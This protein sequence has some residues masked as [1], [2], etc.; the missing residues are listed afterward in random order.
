MPLSPA[1]GRKVLQKYVAIY[2]AHLIN[3]GQ[4]IQALELYT[5]YGAPASQQNFNI[6]KRILTDIVSMSGLNTTKAYKV[7]SSLRNMMYSL[8]LELSQNSDSNDSTRKEYHT[9]LLIS[10]YYA[11][12]AAVQTDLSLNTMAA[13]LSVSLL[14]HTDIVPADK[15]FYEAGLLCKSVGWEAMAFVFTNHLLDIAEAIED[16]TLDSLDHSDFQATDIPFEIP[17]PEHLF[18]SPGELEQQKEW[19]LEVSMNQNV[20]QVLPK[21][22]RGVYEASLVNYQNGQASVPCLI[23][24]YPVLK[25]QM[26]FNQPGIGANKED[27]NKLFMASKV[28]HSPEIQDVLQFVCQWGQVTSD[29]SYSL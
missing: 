21:D 13:K 16:G 8:Y 27:W 11:T 26:P 25:N 28:S 20:E 1:K 3:E 18:L 4:S 14:R 15:A 2:A 23:T 5:M 10:H 7:W 9:Y 17:L 22:E 6:Y 19:V 24:G 29:V 12:R